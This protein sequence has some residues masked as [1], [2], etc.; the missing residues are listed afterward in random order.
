MLRVGG[1]ANWRGSPARIDLTTHLAR[2]ALFDRRLER[3]ILNLFDRQIDLLIV[4][5]KAGKAATLGTLAYTLK[6]VGP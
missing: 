4:G 5:M 1:K 6:R 2:M 3:K